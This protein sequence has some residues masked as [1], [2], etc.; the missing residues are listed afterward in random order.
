MKKEIPKCNFKS[1]CCNAD[2]KVV[3]NTTKHFECKE[4]GKAC[5]I[6]D[7]E[8]YEE[9]LAKEAEEELKEQEN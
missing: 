8:K 9:E 1:K 2:F 4:C 5:D 6:N 7:L 3:G